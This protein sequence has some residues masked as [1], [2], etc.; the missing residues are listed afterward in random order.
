VLVGGMLRVLALLDERDKLLKLL[1]KKVILLLYLLFARRYF[2]CEA[3]NI[4]VAGFKVSVL[5]HE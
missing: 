4:P 3:F 5:R 1:E 2:L